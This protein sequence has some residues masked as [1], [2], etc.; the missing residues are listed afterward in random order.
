M[1]GFG[2]VRV[3]I[4]ERSINVVILLGL[5]L[6]RRYINSKFI[7]WPVALTTDMPLEIM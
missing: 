5:L 1:F 6:V 4:A 3:G 2:C 7:L